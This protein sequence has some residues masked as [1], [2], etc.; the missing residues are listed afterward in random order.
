MIESFSVEEIDRCREAVTK[1]ACVQAL[2]LIA[3]GRAII[4]LSPDRRGN[5]VIVEL[6]GEQVRD[7]DYPDDPS[8]QCGLSGSWPLYGAGLIDV[9]GVVTPA[10][11]KLLAE[12]SA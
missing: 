3:S 12:A 6:D 2:A 9:F 11:W 8:R 10:G 1:P 7:P 5:V 4:E